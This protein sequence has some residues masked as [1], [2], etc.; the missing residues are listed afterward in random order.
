MNGPSTPRNNSNL[1]GN[2]GDRVSLHIV[3]QMGGKDRAATRES[4][5]IFGLSTKGSFPAIANAR[6]GVTRSREANTE[7]REMKTMAFILEVIAI[8]CLTQ[9]AIFFY[10]TDLS[11]A[12]ERHPAAFRL[13]I[14][15]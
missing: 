11:P 10:M 8:F 15:E 3:D 14:S 1:G 5:S 6:I 13:E 9:A 4:P 12:S 2:R 7:E